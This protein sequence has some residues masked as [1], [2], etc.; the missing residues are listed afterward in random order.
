MI[1]GQALLR[2]HWTSQGS[3]TVLELRFSGRKMQLVVRPHKQQPCFDTAQLSLG[4]H[5]WLLYNTPRIV[6]LKSSG[7][8]I[9]S[10]LRQIPPQLHLTHQ[11]VTAYSSRGHHRQA[12]DSPDAFEDSLTHVGGLV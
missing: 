9:K 2:A 6:R 7:R 12:R 8:I 5:P 3:T 10:T 4:G 1:S 11:R